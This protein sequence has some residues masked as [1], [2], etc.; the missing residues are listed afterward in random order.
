MQKDAFLLK[1]YILSKND[2]FSTNTI[3][4][5]VEVCVSYHTRYNMME[6]YLFKA[7]ID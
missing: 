1:K 5:L 7:L 2:L 6:V 4:I 3:C